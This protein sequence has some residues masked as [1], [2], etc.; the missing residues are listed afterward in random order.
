MNA[1]R[2]E[3]RRLPNRRRSL[4]FPVEYEGQRFTASVSQFADGRIAE[5]FLTSPKTGTGIAAV[6]HDAAI[7]ISIALQSGVTVEALVHSIKRTVT[8]EPASLIGA[9]LIAVA[10][11][12]R[13]SRS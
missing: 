5:L 6:A 13:E 11:I 7:I 9:A 4:S 12:E 8:G 1:P 3:R 10:A 2:A